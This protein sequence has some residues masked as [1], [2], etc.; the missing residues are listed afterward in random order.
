MGTIHHRLFIS[1]LQL[2]R[3]QFEP[4]SQKF[5]IQEDMRFFEFLQCSIA[6]YQNDERRTKTYSHIDRELGEKTEGMCLRFVGLCADYDK[7]VSNNVDGK[8]TNYKF[9]L[10]PGTKSIESKEKIQ[11]ILAKAYQPMGIRP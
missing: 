8:L 5:R 4:S 11:D 6:S 9:H 10:Y 3:R 1:D 7:D 2:Q